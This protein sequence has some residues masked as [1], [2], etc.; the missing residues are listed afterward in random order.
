MVQPAGT[1]ATP[2]NGAIVVPVL[3]NTQVS[4]SQLLSV[5]TLTVGAPITPTAVQPLMHIGCTNN[6]ITYRLEGQENLPP[7]SSNGVQQPQ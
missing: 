2:G 7:E 6:V 4:M 3:E 5:N 1:G